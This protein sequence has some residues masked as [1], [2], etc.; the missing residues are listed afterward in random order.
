MIDP[1]SKLKGFVLRWTC[2]LFYKRI[3]KRCSFHGRIRLPSPLRNVTI[4]DD[5][6]IGDAVFFHTGRRSEIVIGSNCSVNSGCHLVASERIIIG[7]NVAIAEYVSIRDNE[8]RFAPKTGVRG[9]GYNVAPIIIGS[10]VWIGRGVYVGP[11]TVIENGSII[12]AN[13]VVRGI[14]PPGVLIAGSP[15]LVK[16]TLA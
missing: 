2:P 14:F 13:S 8:H 5:C 9:Q 12:G 1:I 16:K 10:N 4:G 11:G 6:M 3:G 15:A 7:D